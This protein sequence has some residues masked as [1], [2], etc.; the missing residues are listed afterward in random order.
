MNGGERDERL[1]VAAV[2][3]AC[4]VLHA[5]YKGPGSLSLTE[6][7]GTTGLGKSAVQR[8]LHTLVCLGYLRQDR[9]TR[10]YALAPKVLDLT[11]AYLRHDSFLEKAFPYLL[12]ASKRTNETV[13]LTELDDTDILYVSRF[14][15][16][17]VISVDIVLGAR[18][19]AFCTAPGRVMLAQMDEAA[20][21]DI[22]DRS[23]LVARTPHTE[24]D[25]GRLL[26]LLRRIREQGYAISNQETFIGDIST[27]APITNHNGQV[28]AAVNIAVPAPRW[29]PRQVER[30]LTPIV[31][32]TAR[33][34]SKALGYRV[35]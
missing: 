17:K 24:T 23:N 35:S 6:V 16:R 32:E 4:K 3:K 8:Y 13:N 21:S 7:I 31:I 25:R 12:E 5:F 19:P 14:P 1:F 20:V 11:Y 10:R 22:L 18:L 29:S 26:Q 2:E 30:K 15:S 27:A 34:I 9:S 33:A 28:V